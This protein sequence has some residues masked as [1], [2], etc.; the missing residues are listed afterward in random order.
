MISF[1]GCWA[2]LLAAGSGSRMAGCANGMS[3]Q[4]LP[5]RGMP[6]YLHSA[7][8]LARSPHVEGIVFVFPSNYLEA[9]ENRIK[10]LWARENPGVFWKITSGGATRRDSARNGLKLA[11]RGCRQVLIHDAAR[12]FL[13]PELVARVCAELD[14][15]AKCV[16]PVIPVTDTLK[17]VSADNPSV[18]ETTLPRQ[19]IFAAQTPQG[20]DEKSLRLAHERFPDSLVTDDA[21]LMEMLGIPTRVCPGDVANIKITTP[22]DMKLL[23]E[24][25]YPQYRVGYGYDAHRYGAGHP[26]KLGAVAI[27]GQFEVIAHSDGDVLLH[28]LMDA[29]CGCASLGDIGQIFPD[30]DPALRGISSSILLDHLLNLM[31][32]KNVKL[33]NVDMTIVAQKPRIAP[34][35]DEIRRNVARLLGLPL[36]CVNVK[37]TTEEGMGFTGSLE[38][39]KACA[40]ANAV[41][42]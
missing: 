2:I 29:I 19:R 30:S 28:A 25:S 1:Q 41:I 18:V 3:K 40:I 5:W 10:D 24:T 7:L 37:A 33:L 8:S 9:E 26:L 34:F 22:D 21:M 12:P 23:R 13:S 17:L 39:I 31:A 14:N 4:F 6:L 38:G 42:L 32:G 11:P 35:R 27:P 36:D 15:G 20:F 16:T